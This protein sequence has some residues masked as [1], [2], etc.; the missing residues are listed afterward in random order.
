MISVVANGL[1]T[2][3]N[4]IVGPEKK[5]SRDA[6]RRVNYKNYQLIRM[7]PNTE[8]HIADLHELKDAEPEDIK[9]WSFPMPNRFVS[10]STE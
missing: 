1:S 8:N 6:A 10:H 2:V 4:N 7:F 5:N 3:V 9:F